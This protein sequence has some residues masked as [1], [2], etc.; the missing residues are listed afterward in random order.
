MNVAVEAPAGTVILGTDAASAVTELEMVRM[1]PPAG[2]DSLSVTVAVD[3]PPLPPAT[4][5]G[6]NVTDA[7]VATALTEWPNAPESRSVSAE[8]SRALTGFLDVLMS[9]LPFR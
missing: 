7:T 2:A 5:A 3:V 4:V 8:S 9:D 1:L 6:F